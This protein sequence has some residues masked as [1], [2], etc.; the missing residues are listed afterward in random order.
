MLEPF[1]KKPKP[2]FVIRLVGRGIRPWRV[3]MRSLAKVM[4]AVQRLVEQRDDM[5]DDIESS[6]VVEDESRSILHLLGVT[7]SSAAYAVAAPDE[8][9]VIETLE[10][11]QA[12]IRAPERADWLDSTLSSVREI[13]DIAKALDCE[14]EFRK[15]RFRT[16]GLGD[17]VI[18]KITP[19]TFSEI[20]GAAYI[21]ASTSVY[22]K[23]ERIG[24][25]TDMHCGIRLPGAP[26]KM[27]ICRV[28]SAELVRELGQ[29]IYQYVVISGQTTWLR[30]NWRLKR[31]I[32]S[33][34]EPP[35][36][37]RISDTL[38]C[39][40]EVGGDAWDALE[41]PKAFMAEIR[42]A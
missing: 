5:V 9:R 39:V 37:G 36:T 26:Q 10:A 40:R 42:G 7:S 2:T 11:V 34:F 32:I 3:P 38:R 15:P 21:T 8:S 23:V 25:A 17:D 4:Q 27:V 1:K 18:A 12:D 33:A 19:I 31:M 24:G 20:E 14:I 29:Y 41:N 30:H 13:S 16:M 22:A 28:Q 6:T 35:K